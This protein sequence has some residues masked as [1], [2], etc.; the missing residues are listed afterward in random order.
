[1]FIE[2]SFEKKLFIYFPF[3]LLISFIREHIMDKFEFGNNDAFIYHLARIF[4][5]IFYIFE[6]FLSKGNTKSEDEKLVFRDPNEIY[7]EIKTKNN[8]T[9]QLFII[10][11]CLLLFTIISEHLSLYFK[12]LSQLNI[13]FLFL[14]LINNI[15]FE[16]NIYSH[17][18]FSIIINIIAIICGIF[19]TRIKII[20]LIYLILGGYCECFSYLLIKY[21]NTQYFINIYFLGFLEGTSLLISYIINQVIKG[22]KFIEI[23]QLPIYKYIFSISVLFAFFFLKYKVIYELNPFYFFILDNVPYYIY[24]IITT[25]KFLDIIQFPIIILSFLIYIEIIQLNFFGLSDNTRKSIIKRGK[26]E[27]NINLSYFSTNETL[28]GSQIGLYE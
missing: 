28:L 10:I 9:I 18:I 19:V 1:M 16:K 22:E 25:Q 6:K 7:E 11:L 5:I 2:F 17:Q 15:F 23:N 13:T 21:I 20:L 26:K 27:F 12:E 4:M 14:F 8:K 24:I 3:F